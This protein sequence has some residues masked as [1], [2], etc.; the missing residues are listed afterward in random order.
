MRRRID[1]TTGQSPSQMLLGRNHPHPGEWNFDFNEATQGRVDD[2]R[3]AKLRS[4]PSWWPRTMG[5]YEWETPY[6][7]KICEEKKKCLSHHMPRLRTQP[8]NQMT[9]R[10]PGRR[11]YKHSPCLRKATFRVFLLLHLLHLPLGLHRCPDQHEPRA[12]QRTSKKLHQRTRWTEL[13]WREVLRFRL[14]TTSQA[15]ARTY[16]PNVTSLS[17]P[18]RCQ[19]SRTS[20]QSRRL[21]V[22]VEGPRIESAQGGQTSWRALSVTTA[23]I[24]ALKRTSELKI[25]PSVGVVGVKTC[26][27]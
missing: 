2:A 17:P 26:T 14:L 23:A 16:R 18:T 5:P 7:P 25:I 12:H 19:I 1:R 8:S 27:R 13:L 11:L 6:S 21:G 3:N 22:D 20:P 4:P 15:R 9:H 24:C 10:A